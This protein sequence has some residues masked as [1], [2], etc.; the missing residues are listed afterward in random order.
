MGSSPVVVARSP[1]GA[2]PRR[3]DRPGRSNLV[4]QLGHRVEHPHAAGRARPGSSGRC[5]PPPAPATRAC[6]AT[7]SSTRTCS[8]SAAG[9]GL[10]ATLVFATCG[11]VDAGLAGRPAAARRVRRARSSRWPSTYLVGAAFGAAAHRRHARAR[12]RG[13]HVAGDGDPDV[14]AAAQHRRH[15][16]GLHRGSSGGFTGRRGPTCGSCCRTSSSAIGVLLA[17]RRHLD[18]LR[19]GDDEA[20]ALGAPRRA[21]CGSSSWSRPRWAPL[22]RVSVSGL[23]GFVGIVVPHFIRLIAGASLSAVLPLSCCSA[24]RS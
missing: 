10:G 14:H 21:G 9:A 11:G 15:P 12:R 4:G 1:L 13:R 18:V 2:R 19:V 8:A 7:R 23:I 20:A 3:D 17:H 5:C 24:P 22:P 6:S 16:R